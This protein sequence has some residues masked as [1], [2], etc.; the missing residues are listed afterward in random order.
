MSPRS[1]CE[2]ISTDRAG[3]VG[4]TDS[5]LSP[6]RGEPGGWA[7][8]VGS[9]DQGLEERGNSISARRTYM[10]IRYGYAARGREGT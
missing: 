10:N 2:Q 3:V 7:R 1:M 8:S 9:G 6:K 5:G 4:G